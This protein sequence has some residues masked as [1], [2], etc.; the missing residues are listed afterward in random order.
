[1]SQKQT[2]QKIPSKKELEKRSVKHKIGEMA[3]V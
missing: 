2:Q 1:M 3:D